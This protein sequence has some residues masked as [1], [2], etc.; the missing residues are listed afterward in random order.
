[1]NL[2]NDPVMLLSVVNTQ[3]RDRYKNLQE[4]CD[5]YAIDIHQ[6]KEKLS[7]NHF[8]YDDKQNQFK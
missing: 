8:L 4:L 6:L 1:M 3:L 5:D 7:R 2:P